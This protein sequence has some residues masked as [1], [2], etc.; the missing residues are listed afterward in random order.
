MAYQTELTASILAANP[1]Q[2]QQNIEQLIS[3]GIQSLHIDVM[4]HHYV[5][6][7]AINFDTITEIAATFPLLHLD[8]HLM[9]NNIDAAI[10]RV[11]S[12]QPRMISFHPQT[13]K[14]PLKTIQK[15]Q[16]ICTASIAINPD[17]HLQP[18]LDLLNH[19][20]HCLLMGVQPGKCGQKFQEK[21]LDTLQRIHQQRGNAIKLAVDGGI[22]KDTLA[23]VL[24]QNVPI[25]EAIVGSALFKNG[26]LA[27]NYQQ[28]RE[29]LNAHKTIQMT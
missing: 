1:L 14:R 29:V 22:N 12:T 7:L 20:D 21:T 5:D 4:D 24:E 9:V 27:Q 11:A 13:T 2:L 19:A 28:L 16:E 25:D 17:D 15:I 6:N 26:N 10:E 3:I 23:L 18:P 8:I